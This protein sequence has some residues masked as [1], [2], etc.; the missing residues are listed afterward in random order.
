[1]KLTVA[2]CDDDP[3]IIIE[4]TELIR[5]N[6]PDYVIDSYHNGNDVLN[7]EAAYDLIFLDIEMPG[8]NGMELAHRLRSRGDE[9]KIVFLTGYSEFMPEAFVVSAYRY[10]NKPIESE[11][12]IETLNRAEEE[13]FRDSKTILASYGL[14]ILIKIKDIRYIEA[15][16]NHTHVHMSEKTIEVNDTL[17][18]WGDKLSGMNFVQIHKSYLVSLAWISAIEPN[19]IILRGDKTALPLSRRNSNAVREAFY[20]Y[21]RNNST[22]I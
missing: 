3:Q 18:V 7:A 11:N 8:M 1:M 21:I 6:K 12:L 13:V 17:K 15:K 10:L 16:R 5:R 19:R 9:V 4:L 2:I 14:E 22:I 20:E